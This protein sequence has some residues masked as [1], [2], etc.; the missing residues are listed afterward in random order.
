MAE[1]TTNP[2]ETG[3]QTLSRRDR[4]SRALRRWDTPYAN[5]F[6]FMNRITEEMDQWFDRVTR[7]FGVP[8]RTFARGGFGTQLQPGIWSPRAEAFQKGDKF[9][10][11]AELPGLKKEDVNVELTDD[12]LTIRG[13]RREE[14]QE[15]REGF[16]HSEREYGEFYRTIPL[17]EGVIAES[18]QANFKDGV[19]E[20][21]MQAAPSEANRGRR[22]VIRDGSQTDQK[23]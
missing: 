9:I 13:E 1:A 16:Y 12:V 22:L 17:P 23:K 2:K 6:E 14:R 10:V 4:E 20:I 11:R 19:L 7:D 8:R 21:T 3:G 18:A 5:P 15:E